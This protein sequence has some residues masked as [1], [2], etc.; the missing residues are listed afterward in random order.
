METIQSYAAISASATSAADAGQGTQSNPYPE[1][2][3]AHDAWL[4]AFYRREREL[5]GEEYA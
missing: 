4:S 3:A 1:H 2:S 5:N